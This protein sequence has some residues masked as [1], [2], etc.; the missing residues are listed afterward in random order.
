MKNR[1]ISLLMAVCMTGILGI[2]NVRPVSAEEMV[3]ETEEV[4]GVTVSESEDTR[5]DSITAQADSQIYFTSEYP[6]VG[7]ELGVEVTGMTGNLS[8]EWKVDGVIK[9]RD[10]AYTPLQEDL[11]KFISVTV[12]DSKGSSLSKQ[13]F[14][15][16]LPVIY[17]NTENGAVIGDKENYITSEFIIQGNET[18]NS[19]T[20]TLYNGT[21]G[22]RG[23]GNSTWSLPKKPYKVKLDKGTDLFGFGKSKH[24][25]LLANY[26][27]TSFIRNKL[28]YDLSGDMGIPYMQSVLADVVL[29]G[30]YVGNY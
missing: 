11:E 25:V 9:G 20:T 4:L 7:K 1:V 12:K 17:I 14:F 16:R 30:V 23:R 21:A 6:A 8:Y 26:Y 19:E 22:V 3:S 13:V 5:A 29:N 28:A 15:S 2:G 18:Y 24:W 10:A 27:D